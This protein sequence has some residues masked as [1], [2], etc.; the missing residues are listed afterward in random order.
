MIDYYEWFVVG[1]L[2]FLLKSDVFH[3]FFVIID[4][5][6]NYCFQCLFN[7]NIDHTLSNVV[8]KTNLRLSLVKL[9]YERRKILSKNS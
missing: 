7:V 9:Y 2:I 8:K 4:Y 3:H 1:G 6:N 5:Y